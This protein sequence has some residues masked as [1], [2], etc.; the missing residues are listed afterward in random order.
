MYGGTITTRGG[1]RTQ[2]LTIRRD[3]L[4]GYARALRLFGDVIRGAG[5]A[6][7]FTGSLAQ[8]IQLA[9]FKP[10]WFSG[11]PCLVPTSLKV[12]S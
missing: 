1:N 5:R 12:K 11:S 10:A 9:A 4:G 8:S 6:D 3:D 7:Q 2:V